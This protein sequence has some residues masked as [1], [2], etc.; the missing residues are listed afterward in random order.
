MISLKAFMGQSVVFLNL[1]HNIVLVL[2]ATLGK[3]LGADLGKPL[4]VSEEKVF[5]QETQAVIH[6]PQLV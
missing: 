1:L 6:Y 2:C 3:S 5:L 4:I